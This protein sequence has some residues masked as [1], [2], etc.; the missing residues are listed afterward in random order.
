MDLNS[1]F[2]LVAVA[3]FSLGALFWYA[4]IARRTPQKNFFSLSNAFLPFVSLTFLLAVLL[5]FLNAKRLDYLFPLSL[6]QLCIPFAGALLIRLSGSQNFLNRWQ[7]AVILLSAAGT[8]FLADYP[9]LL[10]PDS[11]CWLNWGALTLILYASSFSFKYFNAV[12]GIAAVQIQPVL[13]GISL[14]A[15]IGAVPLFYGWLSLGMALILLAF[16][17]YNW[18][19]AQISWSVP[20]CQAAGFI[21]GWLALQCSAEGSGPCLVIFA[22]LLQTEFVIA[23]LKKLTFLKDYRNILNNTFYYQINISGLSPA[24]ICRSLLRIEIL[25]VIFGCFELYAPNAYSLP[26][27]CFIT[28]LWFLNRLLNWQT[29]DQTLSEINREVIDDIKQAFNKDNKKP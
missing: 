13:W 14:L 12:D 6:P 7:P 8:V 16:L 27:L 15:W 11:P 20:S 22:M 17:L 1:V 19:P 21:L 25:L 24:E 9:S 2:S 29:P 23:L 18:Y 3:V 5:W 28:T 26:I 4:Q 10:F